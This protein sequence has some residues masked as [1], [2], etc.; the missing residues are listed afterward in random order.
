MLPPAQPESRRHK[1]HLVTQSHSRRRDTIDFSTG[2][3][4]LLAHFSIMLL[5]MVKMS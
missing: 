3:Q 2:M 5:V 4:V 1:S